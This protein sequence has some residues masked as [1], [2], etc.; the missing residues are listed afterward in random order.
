MSTTV[1]P[2]RNGVARFVSV[3]A[4]SLFFGIHPGSS[5]CWVQGFNTTCTEFTANPDCDEHCL[6]S[7]DCDELQVRLVYHIPICEEAEPME[8]GQVDC[9]S[10][11]QWM[12][13]ELWQ[14]VH[15]HGAGSIRCQEGSTKRLC[16]QDYLIAYSTQTGY[17]PSGSS[18]TG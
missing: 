14:C 13:W 18:C 15:H 11:G 5:T 2:N 16:E 3:I 6:H 12:C 7:D 4:S 1:N 10:A 8:P 9:D 17:A